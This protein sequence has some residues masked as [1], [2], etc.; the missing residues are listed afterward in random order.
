MLT[1]LHMSFGHHNVTC[2]HQNV[3]FHCHTACLHTDKYPTGLSDLGQC[4]LTS[5]KLVRVGTSAWVSLKH[6]GQQKWFHP[7]TRNTVGLRLGVTGWGQRC[8]IRRDSVE[9]AEAES[10]LPFT[11]DLT[12]WCNAI[13]RHN[14]DDVTE[15]AGDDVIIADLRRSVADGRTLPRLLRMLCGESRVF[16][17]PRLA[18]WWFWDRGRVT[19]VCGCVPFQVPPDKTKVL[20][21]QVIPFHLVQIGIQDYTVTRLPFCNGTFIRFLP[22]FPVFSRDAFASNV[23]LQNIP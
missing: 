3:P 12:S 17:S 13:L 1:L 11:Q 4:H 5:A 23:L 8:E 7:R 10:S 20:H 6:D 15:D 9:G 18:L 16:V 22:F 21:R 2:G 19:R 14:S